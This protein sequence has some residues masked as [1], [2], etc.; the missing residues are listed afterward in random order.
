MNG[1]PHTVKEDV[2]WRPLCSATDG[3]QSSDRRPIGQV[4]QLAANF[5]ESSEHVTLLMVIKPH[6]Q[7]SQSMPQC[8]I[9]RKPVKSKCLRSQAAR[10]R[11]PERI[12]RWKGL[13]DS[14]NLFMVVRLGRS[15]DEA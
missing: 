11:K 14:I 7:Q 12:R 15:E 5:L 8:S 4:V 13:A 1:A 10:V 9:L 6:G 2:A 3:C